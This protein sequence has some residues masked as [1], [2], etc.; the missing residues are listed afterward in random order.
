MKQKLLSELSGVSQSLISQL[1][2]SKTAEVSK[3]TPQLADALKISVDWLAYEI[4]EKPTPSEGDPRSAY[5]TTANVVQ[6]Q[7]SERQDG[8]INEL[9]GISK[10]MSERGIYELIGRAKEIAKA[11]PKAQA[12]HAE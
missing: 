8:P 12:N 6:F 9:I 5:T 11:H 1:E 2:R 7:A 4:G 3:Y 10:T